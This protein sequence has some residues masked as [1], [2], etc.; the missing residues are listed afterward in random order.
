MGDSKTQGNIKIE[1]ILR[2]KDFKQGKE[3][4]IEEMRGRGRLPTTTKFYME[5]Y[6][7]VTKF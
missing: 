7:L 2:E 3:V 6:H 1:G 4:K 5:I